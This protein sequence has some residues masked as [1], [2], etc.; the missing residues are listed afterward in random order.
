M[1]AGVCQDLRSAS[2]RQRG[3]CVVCALHVREGRYFHFSSHVNRLERQRQMRDTHVS[4]VPGTALQLCAI[5]SFGAPPVFH[6]QYPSQ[7][8]FSA[9][10]TAETHV[11]HDLP[12]ALLPFG[13]GGHHIG[14]LIS[15][16]HCARHLSVMILTL[17][18][19]H[20]VFH[21]RFT[22]QEMCHKPVTD[23]NNTWPCMMTVLLKYKQFHEMSLVINGQL[24]S[25]H[26]A[27]FTWIQNNVT[28]PV[29]SY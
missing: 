11:G 4:A 27:I 10:Y 18:Q 29:S 21:I 7:K 23:I 17:Y 5:L 19:Q 14:S 3:M 15:V 28:L 8:E 9:K 26:T 24:S 20:Y 25:S 16:L 13:L 2:Q 22:V 12:L 6:V 1:P